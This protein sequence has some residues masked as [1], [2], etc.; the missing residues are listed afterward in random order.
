VELASELTAEVAD[1]LDNDSHNVVIKCYSFLMS[2]CFVDTSLI[3]SLLEDCITEC[4][5][6]SLSS[7]GSTRE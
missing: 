3:L 2:Y 7:L 5:L 1:L 6:F 4:S